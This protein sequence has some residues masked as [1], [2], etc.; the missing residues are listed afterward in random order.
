[1][2]Y[3]I[4][5]RIKNNS[6]TFS[7]VDEDDY[8]RCKV[9]KWYI[10]KDSYVISSRNGRMHRFIMNSKPGE[11]MIDHINGDKLDNRKSNLRLATSFQNAQNKLKKEGVTSKYI[12]VSLVKK[13]G[14]WL[15]GVS[16][17]NGEKKYNVSFDNEEHAAYWYDVNVLKN[18]GPGA[19]INRVDRPVN[20]VE[21][22]KII[23]RKPEKEI[24]F[25]K[26]VKMNSEN[27]PIITTSKKEDVLV[28][29]DKYHDLVRYSWIIHKGYAQASINGRTKYM[30]R[31]LMEVESTDCL[32]DHINNNR[33]DNRLVNLRKSDPCHNSHNRKKRLGC[34]SKYKGVSKRNNI[35]LAY[36]C[37]DKI[38]YQLGS[39]KTEEAAALAYNIKASELYGP[40]AKLN[41]I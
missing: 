14:K 22:V 24:D 31:Y 6:N 25:S 7:K 18:Y 4:P 5:I 9:I 35:Y 34:S 16:Q 30:H 19:K 20:F 2:E 32:I 41:I 29:H 26:E 39:F 1:M 27:I 12:G 10:D 13:S 17:G 23:T 21:P 37:K 40:N 28:D 38:Q 36:I 33:L 11:P 15:C 3:L 8:E